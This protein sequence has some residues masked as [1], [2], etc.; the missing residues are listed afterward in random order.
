MS[1]KLTYYERNKEKVKAYAKARYYANRGRKIETAKS[2]YQVNREDRIN[3]AKQRRVENYDKVRERERSYIKKAFD[4][5]AVGLMWR[6]KKANAKHK[7][8]EFDITKEDLQEIMVDVCPV[9]GIPLKFNFGGRA[10]CNHDSY[11]I[12]RI[13][14][15][16]GYVKGNIQ[17]M[18]KRANLLK[19]DATIEELEKLL[20]YMRKQQ[21]DK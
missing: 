10:G 21:G 19:N 6:V 17:I 4:K 13:D 14:N 7:G 8:V 20:A 12:D 16:K 2:Y 5:D 1:E 15:S 3:Y 11:S 9:L 18:S